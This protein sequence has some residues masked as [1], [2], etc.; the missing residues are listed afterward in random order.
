[1]TA[2]QDKCT[3]N[4]YNIIETSWYCI[5]LF[6]DICLLGLFLCFVSVTLEMP[7]CLVFAEIKID[8]S[9]PVVEGQKVTVTC[10]YPSTVLGDRHLVINGNR[11]GN[12]PGLTNT[13]M[14]FIVAST[15]AVTGKV[16]VRQSTSSIKADFV[17]TANRS[18]TG[19]VLKCVYLSANANASIL[20]SESLPISLNVQC[21]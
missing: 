14:D 3:P 16:T 17:F 15:P 9:K 12:I 7:R 19:Y 10:D 8:V 21:M 6:F 4:D 18:F 20:K 1:M 11:S 5:V 13:P 2:F